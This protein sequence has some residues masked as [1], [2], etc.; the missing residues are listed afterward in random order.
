V[1][2]LGLRLELHAVSRGTALTAG[3]PARIRRG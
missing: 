3:V 1:E 2:A